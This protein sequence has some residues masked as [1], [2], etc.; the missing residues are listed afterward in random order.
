MLLPAQDF[1]KNVSLTF[2]TA[3]AQIFHPPSSAPTYIV[4]GIRWRRAP[5]DPS[6]RLY[7]RC[8]W[9]VKKDDECGIFQQEG[10]KM[11]EHIIEAHLHG[12][13]KDDGKWDLTSAPPGRRYMC[14]WANCSRFAPEGTDNLFEAGMHMK[15]HFDT[16]SKPPS[17]DKTNEHAT[18]KKTRG[19][20]IQLP[21]LYITAT[22]E[23]GVASGLPL[24]AA[25]ILRNLARNL[26]RVERAPDMQESWTERLFRPVEKQL[27]FVM[28]HNKP[29]VTYMAD[30][31]E[32]IDAGK[33]VDA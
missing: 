7:Q 17:D 24:T 26:P 30:L 16:P 23:A 1:I 10:Q 12:R 21:P 20:K 5:V 25:L 32:T 29:L 28:A 3:T 4:K 33:E 11:W 31:I 15:I 9:R 19:E 8:Q 18:A 6:G 13:K 27:W 22:D 14:H 2:N